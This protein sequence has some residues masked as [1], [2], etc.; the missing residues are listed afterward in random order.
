MMMMM[1]KLIRIV[2]RRRRRIVGRRRGIQ[3]WLGSSSAVTHVFLWSV[4]VRFS[5]NGERFFWYPKIKDTST[6]RSSTVV[7]SRKLIQEPDTTNHPI[8]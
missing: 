7:K 3:S 8:E 4:V 5:I 2:G 6:T 1:M